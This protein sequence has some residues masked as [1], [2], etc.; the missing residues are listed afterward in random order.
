M[1]IKAKALHKELFH[2]FLNEAPTLELSQR[3]LYHRI[4]PNLFHLGGNVDT[5][6][7]QLQRLK[8]IVEE[9]RGIK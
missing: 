4:K 9:L 8:E 7:G 1:L 2:L 3:G 6:T 5:S